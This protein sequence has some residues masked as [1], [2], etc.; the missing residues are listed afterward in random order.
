MGGLD[1]PHEEQEALL[2][3]IDPE[4]EEY[5]L[6]SNQPSLPSTQTSHSSL[7]DRRRADA[8]GFDVDP[9]AAVEAR[10]RVA[11]DQFVEGYE[12]SKWEIRAYYGYYVG[13]T[14]LTLAIFA[15]MAMQNLVSLA[16]GKKSM[17]PF[18]GR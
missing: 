6:S 16:A 5:S 3:N 1:G 10:Q 15:S 9:E 7:A 17:L 13:N 11:P 14:G 8:D 12:T 2:L 4:D 18:L